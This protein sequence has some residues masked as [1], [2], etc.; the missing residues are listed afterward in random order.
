[1][2]NLNLLSNLFQK[3]HY[4]ENKSAILIREKRHK[5]LSL[6]YKQGP[7]HMKLCVREREA[8]KVIIN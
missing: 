8:T 7:E 2:R 6:L 4:K 3:F 5:D 1:M